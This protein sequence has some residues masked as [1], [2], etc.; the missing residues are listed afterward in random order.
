MQTWLEKLN[1]HF[2]LRYSAWFL[3]AVG[4]VVSLSLSLLMRMPSG[5]DWVLPSIFAGL[6]LLGVRDTR[7]GTHSVLRNYPVIGHMRYLF[8]FIRPEIRQ[9][10][11]ARWS[12]SAP[13]ATRTSGPSARR[14][15][16]APRATSGSTIRCTRPTCRPMISGWSLVAAMAIPRTPRVLME[17]HAR[18]LTRPASSISR[19]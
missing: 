19:R 11:I 15:T 7:Q 3:C 9:Y 4:L 1:H 18:S 12:T 8:E 14:R 16:S 6:V 10:F 13:R 17:P 5:W 2:P